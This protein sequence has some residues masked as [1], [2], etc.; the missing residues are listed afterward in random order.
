MKPVKTNFIPENLRSFRI[1]ILGLLIT[2]LHNTYAQDSIVTDSTTTPFRKGRW[3]SGITGGI[4]SSKVEIESEEDPTSSNEYSINIIGGNFI[5]DRWL[6]GGIIQLDRSDADG[7]ADFTT[8]TLFIG[9]LVTRYLSDAERGALYLSLSPGYTRYRNLV[10]FSDVQ[11]ENEEQSEGSG[12]GLYISLGYSYVVLDRITFDIGVGLAQRWLDVE[13]STQ[14]GDVVFSDS[15][16]L[17]DLS[18]TF[19]FRVLL[20]SF[21]Q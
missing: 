5:Q 12:F 2:L 17:R 21:L 9:P 8:E 10:R 3:L 1:I 14:P 4:N 19:G 11:T 6:L 18:F 20:D 13:R 16:N 7:L 15:I